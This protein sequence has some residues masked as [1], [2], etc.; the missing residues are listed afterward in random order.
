MQREVGGFISSSTPTKYNAKQLMKFTLSHLKQHL[1]TTASLETIC[2]T[3]T[4]IGL[5]VESLDDKAKSLSQFRVAKI[6]DA[7]K[8]ENSDKLKICQV[9]VFGLEKPLQV[10]CGG[11]NARAGIKVAFAEIGA[12]IPSNQMV[13]KK[14]KIAGYES[15]GMLC[16]AAELGLNVDDK[17]GIIEI[18]EQW[19]LGTTIP[20][21]FSLNDAVIEINVTPN[22]GDC[23]GVYGIARDLAAAGIGELKKLNISE[24]KSS[25]NS[26]IKINNLASELCSFAAFRYIRGVKNC[27]SPTWLKETLSAVG[28]NS[29]SAIVD[30]TNFVML[31]LNRPM[32]AYDAKKINGDLE[33]RFAKDGEKFTSLKNDE[34][35]L[36][37][38]ILVIS[39]ANKTVG[40]A[41]IIG[42]NNTACDLETSE[43]LLEA[44]FF[45]ATMIANTGRKLNI[46]TDARYRFER[47]IDD[48]S[49]EDGI[50]LA[51]KLITE[52]CG[53]EVSEIINVGKESATKKIN[54]DTSLIKKLIGVEVSK[55]KVI[56]ILSN[57]GFGIEEKSSNEFIVEIPTHRSDIA[58]APDLVEEVIRI[59]GYDKINPQKLEVTASNKSI[60]ILHKVRSHL[61]SSGMIETINW[62][63]C[64]E[65]LVEVFAEK[66]E[67]FLLKNPISSELSHLR[68]S[69]LVGLIQSYKKNV[70]RNFSNLSFFE[71]GN[72]FNQSE[73]MSIAGIRA[74]RSLDKSHYNDDRD[75]DIFDVKKDFFEVIEIFGMKPES[76]QVDTAN[77]PKYFHPHRFAALKLGKN[78]VGYFGEINPKISK[79][80]INAFEIFTQNLPQEQKP[81]SFK[82]FK[83]ND[84]QAVERDYAFL[85]NKNCAVNDVIKTVFSCD[86]NLIKEVNI[87]DIYTGKNIDEDK[88]S[89]ALRVVIQPLEKTLTSEEIEILSKSIIGTVEKNHQ[90]ILRS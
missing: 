50:A 47:G 19:P 36:D 7:K 55:N 81:I 84:L 42:S 45:D 87:F 41:G 16:S 76:L 58:I 40:I 61:A 8:A 37:E 52:I 3:L 53:G 46:L 27:E 17:G 80:R 56:E 24:V 44:A 14:A 38:K 54:L 74:G 77:P 1:S 15:N 34:F 5:E 35:N 12:V 25:I 70:L 69:L 6:I 83:T 57:L 22:R 90:A 29:I 59:F 18:E 64:D 26:P 63:F 49:C 82:A 13:I 51:T 66:N 33:I 23:L 31:D 30:I 11:I 88:Q 20:E 60:N 48:K 73:K 72:I 86:K 2:Q 43:I 75:F 79:T 10:I 21:V 89:L 78:L 9:E 68:P 39:D 67:K 65:N 71:I 32:H 4:N 28:I 85:I 62:S